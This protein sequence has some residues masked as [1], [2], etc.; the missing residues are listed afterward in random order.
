MAL[1]RLEK[2]YT[3]KR[4]HNQHL[5]TTT[6]TT[7]R[8]TTTRV[9]VGIR[10]RIRI[11]MDHATSQQQPPPPPA[12]VAQQKKDVLR[13]LLARQM[14]G[15]VT[16]PK[17]EAFFLIEW[18]WWCHWCRHVDF[19]YETQEQPQDPR[20]HQERRTRVLKLL[21]PGAVLQRPKEDDD[22][23]DDDDSSTKT[24]PPQQPLGAIDNSPLLFGTAVHIQQW[25]ETSTSLRPNL[26]RGYHYE[27]LPREVY[28]ALR[29]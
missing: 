11:R 5:P 2:S 7:A 10:I 6:T 26:V 18:N 28:N 14:A 21:P 19:F 22:D 25:Y 20:A 3:R 16:P 15:C 24:P 12:S 23:D 4:D 17:G 1:D 29:S 9:V 8:T 13:L 27:L